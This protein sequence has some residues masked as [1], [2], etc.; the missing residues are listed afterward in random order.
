MHRE[1][2]QQF[3]I[4][5]WRS[6]A[7]AQLWATQAS[8][9]LDDLTAM[10]EIVVQK[11]PSVEADKAALRRAVFAALVLRTPSEQLFRPMTRAI[12]VAAP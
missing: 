12:R 1:L 10:L 5:P 6:A 3:K 9:D 2:V 4:S 7:E 8:V 11:V